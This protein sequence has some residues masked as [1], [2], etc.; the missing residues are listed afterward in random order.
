MDDRK[1]SD[2][3]APVTNRNDRYDES[4]IVE[5]GTDP[6]DDSEE[7]AIAAVKGHIEKQDWEGR[8]RYD[9]HPVADSDDVKDEKWTTAERGEL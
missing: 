1:E 3:Y 9:L 8:S 6:I 2:I 7:D 5:D 4:R